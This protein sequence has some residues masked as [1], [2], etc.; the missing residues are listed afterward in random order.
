[1]PGEAQLVANRRNMGESSTPAW[2]GPDKSHCSIRGPC[3]AGDCGPTMQNKPNSPGRDCCVA[4]LL[5]MTG[6]GGN[7][8][9]WGL[10]G[11]S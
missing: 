5:A 3:T 9:R 8:L 2:P 11:G 4:P 1:M 7:L 10:L 6:T